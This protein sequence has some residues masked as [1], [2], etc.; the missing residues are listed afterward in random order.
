MHFV[1]RSLHPKS[2]GL[3]LVAVFAASTIFTAPIAFAARP[4][5]TTAARFHTKLLK[6]TPAANDTLATAPTAI[7][8]WFNEQV[9]LKVTTVKLSGAA[10]SVKIGAVTR[11]EKTKDA[12][13]VATIPT[14]L[15]AGSYTV[16]WSVA[17]DD[18]HPVKGTFAFVVKGAK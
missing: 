14:P 15:A 12:P 1:P 16:N 4:V 6:S 10:G 3:A 5:A 9:E 7:S 13:V 2:A 8:L 11:D 18:G 17:G